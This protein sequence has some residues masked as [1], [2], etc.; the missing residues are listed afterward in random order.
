MSIKVIAYNLFFFNHWMRRIIQFTFSYLSHSLIL[1]LVTI[2]YLFL[3]IAMLEFLMFFMNCKI[4][5]FFYLHLFGDIGH[6]SCL[7]K[8]IGWHYESWYGWDEKAKWVAEV[9]NKVSPNSTFIAT[10][11]QKWRSFTKILRYH[12]RRRISWIWC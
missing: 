9:I 3:D 11:K 10:I 6:S 1:S 7:I 8:M 12:I 4:Y 5:D 2:Y